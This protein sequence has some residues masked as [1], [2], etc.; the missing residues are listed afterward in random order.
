MKQLCQQGTACAKGTMSQLFQWTLAP[1]EQ[2]HRQL[3]WDQ[4]AQNVIFMR[5][6]RLLGQPQIFLVDSVVLFGTLGFGTLQEFHACTADGALRSLSCKYL[7]SWTCSLAQRLAACDIQLLMKTTQFL[8]KLGTGLSLK[9][10]PYAGSRYL[11]VKCSVPQ[12][13][14]CRQVTDLSP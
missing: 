8:S 6:R 5:V 2:G 4:P 13:P 10:Q 9:I 12:A 14:E 11:M 1:S 3:C 7:G